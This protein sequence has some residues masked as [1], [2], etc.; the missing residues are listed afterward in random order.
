MANR[1]ALAIVPAATTSDGT[2]GVQPG[3]VSLGV[4][5]LGQDAVG[6]LAK[7]WGTMA[8]CGLAPGQLHREADVRADPV[9][10]V[11]ALNQPA[12]L[13][14]R[15]RDGLRETEHRGRGHVVAAHDGEPAVAV[16]RPQPL[17]D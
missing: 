10:Q 11:D 16:A 6:V 9:A 12:R 3:D 14:M 8:E 7:L 4:S 17:G 13:Q 15:V 5:E 1:K 2:A